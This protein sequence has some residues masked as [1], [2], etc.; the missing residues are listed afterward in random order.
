MT[1][2]CSALDRDTNP[3][4]CSKPPGKQPRV[5]SRSRNEKGRSSCGLRSKVLLQ[6]VSALANLGLEPKQPEPK[7]DLDPGTF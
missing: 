2:L 4:N 6:H 1:H 7:L 5:S 3:D